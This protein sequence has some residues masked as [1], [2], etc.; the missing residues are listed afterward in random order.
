MTELSSIGQSLHLSA[1]DEL[2]IHS[3]YVPVIHIESC[4]AIRGER[5]R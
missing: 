3:H 1:I 2:N 5:K 4:H